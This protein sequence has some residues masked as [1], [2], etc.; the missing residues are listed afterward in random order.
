[1]PVSSKEFLD[2]QAS[3][4]C[5]FTVRCVHGTIT[6]YSQTDFNEDNAD[7]N[8]FKR[9]EKITSQTG[10]NC[11]KNVEIMVPLKYLSNFWRILEMLL[12]NYE[13]NLDLNWF[14]NSVIVTTNI[15]AQAATL[16]ITDTKLYVLVVTL[17]TQDNAKLLE[18]LKSGFKRTINW[19]K[20]QSKVSP[21][22]INQYLDFLTDPSFKE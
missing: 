17:S 11:T 15:A 2:I 4:E 3:T 5:G 22:R 9:K 16:S 8:S 20:Y 6:T 21:E 13:I 19:N 18:Q 7:I 1:M 14:K 12:I 10:D